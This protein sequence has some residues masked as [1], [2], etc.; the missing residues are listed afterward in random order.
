MIP[1][2]TYSRLTGYQNCPRSFYYQYVLKLKPEPTYPDYGGMGSAAHKVL[3]DFN[4]LVSIPT[5]NPKRD[6][7]MLIGEL[8]KREFGTVK[9]YRGN[10][11]K[12]LQNFCRFEVER[13]DRL[14][15]KSL[16]KP[17]YNE[18]SVKG[19]ING[20]EFIGRLDAIYQMEDGAIIPVDYKFTSS[21][22]IKNPQRVQAAIYSL[23]CKNTLGME[24][25]EFQ[26]WFLRHE[27]MIKKVE[28]NDKLIDDLSNQV[29]DV[30]NK[31]ENLE[32]EPKAGE[33]FFCQ[34]L[35]G[36]YDLCMSE[37]EAGL[38]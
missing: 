36:F 1:Y 32:F 21:N 35:C 13:Y 4:N 3:E 37:K 5:D 22:Q 31:I 29:E 10:M 28:I 26:F 15:D 23:M 2:M 17:R 24:F 25:S 9:D 27:N 20:V 33:D 34:N 6:F 30:V 12:G 14:G 7:N 11:A 19:S 18:I 16:F 38:I 8:Y